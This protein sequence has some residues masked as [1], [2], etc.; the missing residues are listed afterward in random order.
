MEASRYLYY[1]PL[2]VLAGVVAKYK[3]AVLAAR[4]LTTEGTEVAEMGIWLRSGRKEER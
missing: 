2:I 3:R 1:C 4:K